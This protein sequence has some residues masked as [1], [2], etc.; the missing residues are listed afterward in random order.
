MEFKLKTISKAG[1]PEAISK[2]ELYRFLNEPEEAESICRDILVVEPEHQ[3]ALR[4]LGL[5][6]T[7]QF[8][9][10]PADRYGEAEELFQALAEHYERLY[11]TGLLH[12]R[13]AKAQMQVGRSPHT[14]V[15]LFEEA[16]RCFAEAEIIRPPDNDD[17]ILRWNRCAR[18]LQSHPGFR[19]EKESEMFDAHDSSP[20]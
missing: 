20:V 16:M 10:D 6:I 1:I 19:E 17:A 8:R 5:A 3:L 14:L 7:D 9:G 4:L 15:P 2:V 18:L 12:E 11:Y 13:R